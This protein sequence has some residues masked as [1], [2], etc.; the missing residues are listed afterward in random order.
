MEKGNWI[1]ICGLVCTD[2]A[3]RKT[4]RN[5]DSRVPDPMRLSAASSCR[6]VTGC[7]SPAAGSREENGREAGG[8]G[9]TE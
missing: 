6:S 8:D 2:R 1:L 4:E 7:N 3:P 5:S 9:L